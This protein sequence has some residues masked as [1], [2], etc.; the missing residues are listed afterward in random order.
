MAKKKINSEEFEG[1]I[2]SLFSMVQSIDNSA[3]IIADSYYSNIQEWIPSGNYIL[4]ACMSGDLFKAIPSGKII[5]YCGPSGC[6]KS[7]MA[8]SCCREA[9]NMG[10]IPIILDSEGAYNADFVSRLGVDPSKVIIKQVNTILET[11]QF[12]SNL[13]K[14]LEEQ[15]EKYGKHDK[16]IIV[17]DSLGNLTTE[18]ERDDTLKGEN[19]VDF[20]KA[21]DTK[22]LFRV[23]ATPLAK[24]QVP[25]IVC[26][27]TYQS[28]SFIPQNIQSSGS[29][30]VYNAS[31]TIEMSAAKLEDKENEVAAKQKAGSDAGT[32]NGILVTAKPI[33][34]RFCRPIKIKFQIPYYKK[35]NPYV[36][37]EQFMTWENS[38]VCRGNLLTQKEYDKLSDSEKQ[39]IYTF[40]YEGETM[41]CQPKETARGLVIKHLGKQVSFIDFFTDKVFTQEYLEYLNENVI[42]PMFQ[43]PD[44]SAF[45]DIKEIEESL[46]INE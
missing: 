36:G 42:H 41:Y 18:K 4:N 33:K 14:K 21:K 26:N 22:A 28:I 34:S 5:T 15:E 8:T 39:K 46:D 23:N 35:P 27:H 32:K 6:G 38:G 37:L 7:Y 13:C 44:Q 43:L 11:S 16:V 31:I 40:E 10:Y 9:Q 3:E 1:G 19:K 17:L 29:G 25:L 2:D 20:N 12:I 30:I 45:D 24:L